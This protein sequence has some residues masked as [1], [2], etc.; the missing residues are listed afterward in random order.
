M[1]HLT[2]LRA[3]AASL[4]LLLIFLRVSAPCTGSSFFTCLASLLASTPQFPRPSFTQYF[5][6]RLPQ[7]VVNQTKVSFVIIGTFCN[8]LR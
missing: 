1:T 3:Y 8:N 4:L 7:Y 2:R 6:I 5:A